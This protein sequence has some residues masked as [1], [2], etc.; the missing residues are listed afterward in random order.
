MADQYYKQFGFAFRIDDKRAIDAVQAVAVVQRKGESHDTQPHGIGS[1]HG[2]GSEFEGLRVTSWFDDI[3]PYFGL[4]GYHVEVDRV[5]ALTLMDAEE[6][7]VTLRKIHKGMAKLADKRGRAKSF[8]DYI[9][10]VS[11]LLGFGVVWVL[12]R[13]NENFIEYTIG[14]GADAIDREVERETQARRES[15]GAQAVAQGA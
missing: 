11:E 12:H 8:G 7:V 3:A 9:A 6:V 14:D 1:S 15:R 5:M 4:M 2:D 13:G 10:R